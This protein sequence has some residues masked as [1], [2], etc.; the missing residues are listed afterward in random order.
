MTIK[1]IVSVVR[2]N[3]K[4]YIGKENNKLICKL[5][6]D[7][8]FFK[9]TTINNTVVMGRK[10]W[11]NMV[12]EHNGTLP[13]RYNIILTNNKENLGKKDGCTE[14]MDINLFERYATNNSDK[15]IYIIGGSEIFDYFLNIS[16]KFKPV[17]IFLTE[18]KNYDASKHG[19]PSILFPRISEKYKMISYSQKYFDYL[20]NV[21]YRFLKYKLINNSTDENN[22]LNLLKEISNNGNDRSDRT[23]T[24]TKSLF[25][26]QIKFNLENETIPI[27]TTRQSYYRTAI[28]EMLWMISG[29]TDSI[30]LENKG[31][32]IWKGNSTREFLDK[33]GLTN[34][35]VGDIGSMYGFILRHVG[36]NYV[37]CITDYSGKGIDQLQRVVNLLKENPYSRR[38]AFSLYNPIY[39]NKG[40]L[41]PCHGIFVQFYVEEKK[42]SSIKYLSC[43]MTQ[44][45]GDMLCGIPINVIFYSILTRIIAMKCG[46]EAKELIINIGDAHIYNT[47]LENL[48]IQ[49]SR[50]PMPFPKLILK[51]DIKDKKFEDIIISD[52]EVI[53]YMCHPK[54]K[55][56]MAI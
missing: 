14:F 5:R 8:E 56:K 21:N 31:V 40:S 15:D 6:S 13:D 27:F 10:T 32:N 11:E 53:G 41:E 12:D 19:I 42:N 18:I 1:L 23:D 30:I 38:I 48:E 22:Y 39:L 54:L 46:M 44:R 43:S 25:G 29:Q 51:S 26:K 49:M 9:E 2:Y 34:L 45:S 20:Y 37:N 52:F 7:M 17:D 28:Y 36:I 4:L 24:G 33:R 35:P 47:H 3:N 55:Y 16:D 50:E